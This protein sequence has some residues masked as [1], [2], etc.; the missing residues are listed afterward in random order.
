VLPLKSNKGFCL[1]LRKFLI[2]ATLILK[3]S[4]K[5]PMTWK[6]LSGS[7]LWHFNFDVLFP[8]SSEKIY[9]QQSKEYKE[10]FS[11]DFSE[12]V[13]NFTEGNKKLI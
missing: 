8:A 12:L 10:C 6:T 5:P 13:S 4:R 9:Q 7:R 11:K 3:V 2:A 1:L